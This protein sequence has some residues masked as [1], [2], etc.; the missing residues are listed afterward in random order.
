MTT[1]AIPY[2]VSLRPASPWI[3]PWQADTLAGLLCWVFARA[4]GPGELRDEILDPARSGDPPF[5]F[6]DAFPGDLL[7]VPAALRARSWAAEQ[8]KAVKRSRWMT[9]EAFKRFLAGESPSPDDLKA[10]AV[11]DLE[12]HLHNTISRATNT[13]GQQGS[14]FSQD[15]FVLDSRSGILGGNGALTL[16]ARV[17]GGFEGQLLELMRELASTGYGADAST[18]RGAFELASGLEPAEWLDGH[19]GEADGCVVLSTFQ[20][21]PRDPTEGEWEAFT[22]YG[23][24]GPDFGLENVF[25]RPMI[26]FRP[27]ACFRTCPDPPI[28]GRPI[29][30]QEIL[31]PE[32]CS[33][34]SERGAQVMH[35]AFGLAVPARL[36]GTE[37]R[38]R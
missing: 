8:R 27:G 25:K 6:S 10:E 20:P 9:S 28:V 5:V 17:R 11:I 16:Y 23:K 7:P 37:G 24:L 34:L 3:T 12:Q 18:G 15:D 35:L 19:R 13:T 36:A 4:R 32:V 14:L 22:K 29:E 1:V 38:P 2:R 30:M 26:M 33:T 21:G 31:A